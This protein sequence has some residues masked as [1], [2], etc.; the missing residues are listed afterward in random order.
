MVISLRK[1]AAQVLGTELFDG[2]YC[3][4]SGVLQIFYACKAF[5]CLIK[6]LKVCKID[7]QF[8]NNVCARVRTERGSMKAVI[9]DLDGTLLDSMGLWRNAPAKYLKSLGVEA[10]PDLAEH[11]LPKTVRGGAEY[12]K[13]EYSLSVGLDEIADGVNGIMEDGYRRTIPLKEGVEQLLKALSERGIPMAIATATDRYLAEAALKR[14]NI[15]HYFKAL[16]T[17]TELG[18]SKSDG[19]DVYFAA[20]KLLGVPADQCAVIEDSPHAA[21]M[22]RSAGFFTVG[23]KDVG[24]GN[25]Q[26]KLIAAS[27]VYTQSFVPTENVLKL[28]GID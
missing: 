27:S 12:L 11:F 16:C 23:V 10:A 19:P 18:V 1:S 3:A 2:K 21:R 4:K 17:C 22:A 6:P 15:A 9:F 20:Q 14:L 7:V 5:N 28:L 26:N 13:E 8:K 24:G 25:D